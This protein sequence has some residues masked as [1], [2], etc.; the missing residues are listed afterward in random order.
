PLLARYGHAKVAM[1]GGCAIGSRPIEQPLKGFEAMGAQVHV[2]NGFVE[3]HV[4]GRL[5]G[6][7]IYLDMPSV[8]ATENIM[9]AAALADGVA[10]IEMC[11]MK[12]EIFV[13]T[14][15]LSKMNVNIFRRAT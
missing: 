5:Q 8:G 12:P 2:G 3:C 11:A 9:I 13:F 4:D 7:K 1:P 15:N 6:A 10:I 14:D